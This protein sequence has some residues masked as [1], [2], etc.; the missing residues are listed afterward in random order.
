MCIRDRSSHELHRGHY[1]SCLVAVPSRFDLVDHI[2]VRS[3]RQ[4]LKAEWRTQAVAQQ[5]LSAVS[6]PSGYRVASV[7]A[8]AV[9]HAN[10]TIDR[11]LLEST[12][13][14]I[15]V[16]SSWL[17]ALLHQIAESERALSAGL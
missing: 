5:S 17:A 11:S 9:A 13:V 6:V 2:A 3:N 1:S 12:L 16:T 8:V 4:A 7:Q 10:T 15:L 14:G